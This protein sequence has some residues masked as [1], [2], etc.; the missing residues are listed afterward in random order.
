MPVIS[1]TT[2]GRFV[3]PGHSA[4]SGPDGVGGLDDVATYEGEGVSYFAT[5]AGSQGWNP[6]ILVSATGFSVRLL[7]R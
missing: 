6:T 3:Q 1:R 2:R 5:S 7:Q 4:L